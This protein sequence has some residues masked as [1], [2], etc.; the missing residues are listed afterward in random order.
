M[1]KAGDYQVARRIVE[2]RAKL[3]G[4]EMTLDYRKRSIAYVQELLAKA[5]KGNWAWRKLEDYFGQD[6]DFT[7]WDYGT[8]RE[9]VN[10]MYD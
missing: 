5:T 9:E 1:R 10:E 8:E 4:Q 3:G 7:A 6:G 2:R